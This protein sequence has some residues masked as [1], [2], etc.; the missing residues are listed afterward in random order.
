MRIG[1][2]TTLLICIIG[3][4]F[5][6]IGQ[7][8][9][10]TYWT[11][12]ISRGF[13][14]FFAAINGLCQSYISDICKPQHVPKYTAR[15]GTVF[16]LVF[17]LGPLFGGLVAKLNYI[18][19]KQI[20]DD[21]PKSLQY[22][23]SLFF[24][25]TITGIATFI[26][27][28]KLKESLP[29]NL[30]IPWTKSKQ[31]STTNGQTYDNSNVASKINAEGSTQKETMHTNVEQNATAVEVLSIMDHPDY[32]DVSKLILNVFDLKKEN[33]IIKQIRFNMKQYENSEKI[34]DE[35]VE[36]CHLDE[37][38]RDHIITA[39]NESR[40]VIDSIPEN[41]TDD[42]LI[43][44]GSISGNHQNGE[45]DNNDDEF[46]RDIDFIDYDQY[47][48]NQEEPIEDL[49]F[50]EGIDF[51]VLF[52]AMLPER[53]RT[54]EFK[55]RLKKYMIIILFITVIMDISTAGHATIFALL[56]S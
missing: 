45:F 53:E 3:I 27:I 40:Y 23:C 18:I 29:E 38:Y 9:S 5:G 46:E 31:K 28:F 49:K 52:E 16:G 17:G 22:Q 25:A 2:K 7:G 51:A 44:I 34:T 11:L 43:N 54:P 12:V 19:L 4:T 15:L 37:V 26:V 47:H 35:I 1:R 6:F 36:A 48:K 8:L 10:N 30:R 32:D 42:R 20:S 21:F 41:R 56:N 14:G 55:W 13:A 50:E 24:G 33:K 39:I